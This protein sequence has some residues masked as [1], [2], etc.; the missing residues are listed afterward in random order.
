[1]IE[2]TTLNGTHLIINSNLIENIQ[3]T[4]DTKITLVNEK[5]YLVHETQDEIIDR[6]IAY[7]RQVFL[8]AVRI[9]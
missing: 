7:N 6:V 3:Q 5:Y 8:N 2:I 9:K 4:P 1:M